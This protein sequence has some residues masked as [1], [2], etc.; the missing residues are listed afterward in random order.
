MDEGGN[1]RTQLY[2]LDGALEPLVVDERFIHPRLAYAFSSTTEPNDVYVYD[3]DARELARAT[4]SPHGVDTTALVEPELHR[5]E[6]FDGES[7]PVFLFRPRGDGPF[8]S[9]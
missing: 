9:S 4:T 8:P 7:I 5:Y 6:S 1:E 2:V 3:L